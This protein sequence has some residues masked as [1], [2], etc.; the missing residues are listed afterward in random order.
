MTD[1]AL[2]MLQWGADKLFKRPLLF[3]LKPEWI[4]RN[5][6]LIVVDVGSDLRGLLRR[7]GN[8]GA[9]YVLLGFEILEKGK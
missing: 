7:P 2:R 9:R 8:E 3:L 4:E 1:R 5:E 6:K